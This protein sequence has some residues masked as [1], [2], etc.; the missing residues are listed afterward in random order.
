MKISFV[1]PVDIRYSHRATERLVYEYARY[2]NKHGIMSQ[3]LV[4]EY[5]LGGMPYEERKGNVDKYKDVPTVAI[6]GAKVRLPFKYDVYA[7]SRLPRSGVVYLPYSIY[8]HIL[9]L[10]FKPAGQKYIIGSHGMHIKEGKMLYKYNFIEDFANSLIR[11]T[12]LSGK[13][14]SKN[15]FYHVINLRQKEYLRGLGIDE[16][17]IFYVPNFIEAKKFRIK[18][19]NDKALR[20]LH[21]GGIDKKAEVMAEVIE[22]LIHD[23]V[24]NEFKFYFVGKREPEKILGYAKIHRNISYLGFI[25]SE[26]AKEKIFSDMDVM[27]VPDIEAF[28]VTM[29]E[30]MAS[31]LAIVSRN[32]AIV[33][34]LNNMDA[35]IVTVRGENVE[36][37][38]SMLKKMLGM[39]RRGKLDRGFRMKSRELAIRNFS[40]ERVLGEFKKALDE[41]VW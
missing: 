20:V 38:V 2:L 13:D 10:I 12:I 31:G 18:T 19:N 32:N 28:P 5:S 8:T 33:A 16:K 34:E 15:V 35:G 22:I 23:G 25:D 36:A 1:T 9:N 40:K 37:Y 6:K 24:L 30:G 41:I 21:I 14:I 39:K 11:S 27:V 26:K 3:V 17:K 29:L 4:P 7:F